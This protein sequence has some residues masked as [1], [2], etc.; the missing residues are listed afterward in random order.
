MVTLVL[1]GCEPLFSLWLNSDS[2]RGHRARIEAL[3]AAGVPRVPAWS[4]DPLHLHALV[5]AQQQLS[6]SSLVVVAQ[7]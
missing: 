6:S 7:W 5:A 3:G 1:R 4:L 2:I